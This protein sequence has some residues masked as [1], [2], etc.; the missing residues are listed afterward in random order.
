M[1]EPSAEMSIAVLLEA[2]PGRSPSPIIPSPEVQRNAS[3]VS[4]PKPNRFSP[5][6]TEPSPEAARALELN[7]IPGRNPSPSM[8]L[9]LVQRN[10]SDREPLK[11]PPTTTAPS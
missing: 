2:P 11:L 6:T 3:P 8:P 9:E 1:T 4:P 10:A 7:D 5:A